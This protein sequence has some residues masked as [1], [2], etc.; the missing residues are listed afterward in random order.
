[1]LDVEIKLNDIE[2]S[3]IEEKDLIEVQRW[4][5]TNNAFLKEETSLEELKDRFLES[6]VSQCEFFL[7]IEKRGKLL[8]MLK[9]RLEFKKESELWI[10]FFYLDDVCDN[11]DL[12]S[13]II[14]HM[15]KYFNKKYGVNIFFS[16]I[17]KDKIGSI[18]LWRNLG[19]NF[20]R[21][22]KNFYNIN[23]KYMDMIIM[24][25]IGV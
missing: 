24:K 20:S 25:K 13:I 14:K 7:K 11:V 17:I 2:I 23:G 21:M 5:E 19:F 15:M 6:Y 1:M 8:G 22:V 9:G 12:H 3:S 18:S 16:R 10:W 4:M